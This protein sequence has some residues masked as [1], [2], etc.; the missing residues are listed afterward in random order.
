MTNKDTTLP[1][2]FSG[3]ANNSMESNLKMEKLI[4]EFEWSETSLGHLDNWPIYFHASVMLMLSSSQPVWIAG[5]EGNL[6]LYNDKFS[7]LMGD[8]DDL[9]LGKPASEFFNVVWDRVERGINNAAQKKI[10]STDESFLIF[11][12]KDEYR[13]EKYLS[14][15]YTPILDRNGK[16]LGTLCN[17][18]DETKNVIGERQNFFLKGLSN[19]ILKA[20]SPLNLISPWGEALVANPQD[21]PFSMVYLIENNAEFKLRTA[22]GVVPGSSVAPLVIPLKDINRSFWPLEEALNTRQPVLVEDLS[23]DDI[24]L[25]KGLWNDPPRHTLVASIGFNNNTVGILILGLSPY[26]PFD[27]FYKEFTQNIHDLISDSLSYQYGLKE[28]QESLSNIFFRAPAAIA[29]VEGSNQVYTLANPLYQKLLGKTEEQLLGHSIREAFPELNGKEVY[30]IFDKVYKTGENFEAHEFKVL[31]D[32]KNDGRIVPCY[33]NFVAQAMKDQEGDMNAVMVH[34]VDVTEQV[35]ARK[36]VVESEEK[37]RSLFRLMDQGFCIME[38]IFDPNNKP[39]D[40]K[41]I[42]LNPMFESQTG[43]KN[44]IGNSARQLIPNL[45]DHWFEIYGNVALTGESYRFVE[46][47]EVMGRWFEGYAFRIGGEHSKKV[48]LLFSDITERRKLELALKKSEENYR[49]ISNTTP[50]MLWVTDENNQCTFL[51]QTWEDFTGQ[52]F[53]EGKGLGWL[54]VVHPDDKERSYNTFFEASGKLEPFTL[55]Y[56]IKSKDG[57]YIWAIDSGAPLISED[58][59]FKGYTGYV[60]EIDERKKVEEKLSSLTQEFALSNEELAAANEEIK[61]GM[62]EL[63]EKNRELFAINTDMDNFIYTASHDLKAP[64]ANIEGLVRSLE[65]NLR[66]DDYNKEAVQNVIGMIYKSVERFRKTILDLTEITKMQKEVPE[67]TTLVDMLE[68]IEDVKQDFNYQLADAKVILEIAVDN[69]QIIF[70]RKKLRSIVYNLIS[71]A[72]KYRSP[73]RQPHIKVTCTALSD[74]ILLMV[75]DNGLGFNDKSAEKI[76]SMFKR[77]HTHVEGTGI[78]LYIVKKMIDDGGGKIE[79]ESKIDKGS[80]FRVYFKKPDLDQV[81]LL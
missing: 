42:E 26:R 53:I 79:V 59:S 29:V 50:V 67:D 3:Q 21:I 38:M 76:F 10:G 74:Y 73:N 23:G 18:I 14:F 69:G 46:G 41:F 75:E 15:F 78:G 31:I 49:F 81:S 36:S 19:R 27:G 12:Q 24:E 63:S 80:T 2:A 70:S 62:E 60:I 45:E 77:L 51:N 20:P 66:N 58:G 33:F 71:N 61:V 13:R 8:D 32:R 44:A 48:A 34:A 57:N 43:L 52:P 55:D 25:P 9:A 40:Y 65:R 11:I 16:Y 5:G 54:D 6:M 56:R 22:S 30:E 35:N 47:S 64:I 37:Y 4:K 68:V 7:A 72:I 1:N 28:K 17:V 39:V